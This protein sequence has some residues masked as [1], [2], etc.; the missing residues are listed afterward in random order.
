[1]TF[2]Q[3]VLLS[4][5]SCL[6]LTNL[7]APVTAKE[8]CD[9]IPSENNGPQFLLPAD[10]IAK[11][12]SSP[13]KE[14]QIAE[15]EDY[16][17][18]P[19]PDAA[20]VAEAINEQYLNLF[21]NSNSLSGSKTISF[22]NY[23]GFGLDNDK[24]ASM[25][26]PLIN[27]VSKAISVP[28]QYD[29]T[30]GYALCVYHNILTYPDCGKFLLAQNPS[31][32][33]NIMGLSGF[34]LSATT[35][36]TQFEN[37]RELAKQIVACA[38]DTEDPLT[39]C[40]A[41]YLANQVTG[42]TSI[43]FA[44]ILLSL[45]NYNAFLK[46]DSKI[47]FSLLSLRESNALSSVFIVVK[48]KDTTNSFF[49]FFIDVVTPSGKK[50]LSNSIPGVYKSIKGSQTAYQLTNRR[51]TG[52][53]GLDR[54]RAKV[55]TDLDPNQTLEQIVYQKINDSQK[56]S[57]SNPLYQSPGSQANYDS[58]DDDKVTV[59]VK[60]DITTTWQ[61]ALRKTI[62]NTYEAF[63]VTPT[64]LI[65][66]LTVEDPDAPL[67]QQFKKKVQ[68]KLKEPTFYPHSI[69][70]SPDRVSTE[71]VTITDPETGTTTTINISYQ[72]QAGNDAPQP[73]GVAD[74]LMFQAKKNGWKKGS[75]PYYQSTCYAQETLK[76]ATS[77]F[78]KYSLS[79]A[80]YIHASG[81]NCRPDPT[82]TKPSTENP[83]VCTQALFNPG[84]C[85]EGQDCVD[86]ICNK[87]TER[88]ID[89]GLLIMIAANENGGLFSCSSNLDSKLHFGC[90]P[91]GHIYP[92][93]IASKLDCAIN[94]LLGYWEKSGHDLNETL[95]FYGYGCNNPYEP[96]RQNCAPIPVEELPWTM[97]GLT[98]PSSLSAVDNAADLAYLK[99][100]IFNDHDPDFW[101]QAYC[102]YFPRLINATGPEGLDE[103]AYSCSKTDN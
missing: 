101:W 65:S 67:G 78:S 61:E 80:N 6:L 99:S 88:N 51:Q 9:H 62:N 27:Y 66:E 54:I 56:I 98:P 41:P 52:Q 71:D 23:D 91:G 24:I 35:R 82:T 96:N 19:L 90:D 59:N 38:N 33:N 47:Q 3:T 34:L 20:M 43:D 40:G 36:K 79:A 30:L 28:D 45:P 100:L 76:K 12:C 53:A 7:V 39:P 31:G 21:S 8:G 1:M 85:P 58:S 5:L 44:N 74:L 63:F 17:V 25:P 48:K 77:W 13:S 102:N 94:T 14:R 22:N 68:A 73:G 29:P 11:K 50:F 72:G 49:A 93:D 32:E 81:S 92:F 70:N 37:K 2:T 95:S 64:A 15:L 84:L 26:P 103:A 4:S 69:S 55:H 97:F 75:D 86:Y 46:L 87:A 16:G 18:I 42:Q 10:P 83:G 57:V 60:I 89:C